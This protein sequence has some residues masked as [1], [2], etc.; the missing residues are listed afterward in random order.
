MV[1]ASA[2]RKRAVKT[3]VPVERRMLKFD[4]RAFDDKKKFRPVGMVRLQTKY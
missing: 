1:V 3:T 2:D 4:T